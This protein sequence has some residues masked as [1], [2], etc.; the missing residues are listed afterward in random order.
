MLDVLLMTARQ[1]GPRT[2]LRAEVTRCILFQLSLL[3]VVILGVLAVTVAAGSDRKSLAILVQG[4]MS[5]WVLLTLRRELQR[6]DQSLTS[7]GV[8]G[9]DVRK[10]F[11]LASA[12]FGLGVLSGMV[13]VCLFLVLIP[14][15]V[16]DVDIDRLPELIK[17]VTA[18]EATVLLL[19]A[20]LWEELVFRAHPVG[21]MLIGSPDCGSAV[22]RSL[23]ICVSALWFSTWHVLHYW[24][25]PSLL[26][27]YIGLGVAL[28]VLYFQ[29]RSIIASWFMHFAYNVVLQYFLAAITGSWSAEH[30][31]V[32]V[33]PGSVRF[34]NLPHLCFGMLLLSTS[35]FVLVVCSPLDGSNVDP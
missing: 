31:A 6:H 30:V 17:S 24:A 8:F 18:V 10:S 35:L 23:T 16:V 28:G 29:T 14:N 11:R 12:G 7:I 15:A 27:V 21:S 4:L 32:K 13:A 26:M 5:A 2:S 25:M 3:P 19:I 20:A 1:I 22:R 34:L 9:G 33:N